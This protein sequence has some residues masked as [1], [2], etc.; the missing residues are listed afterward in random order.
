MH[1]NNTVEA[2]I[3]YPWYIYM[4]ER[5]ASIA[6]TNYCPGSYYLTML[7][8]RNF[9]IIIF[10]QRSNSTGRLHVEKCVSLFVQA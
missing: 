7:V 5:I 8:V 1:G 3:Y 4:V 10:T 9:L 2:Q 6:Y